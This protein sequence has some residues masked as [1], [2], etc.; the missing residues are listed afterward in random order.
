VPQTT[1]VARR[2]GRRALRAG[3]GRLGQR[4]WRGGTDD[5]GAADNRGGAAVWT[6]VTADLGKSTTD[7]GG[8][9]DGGDAAAQTNWYRGRRIGAA[10][11]SFFREVERRGA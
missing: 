2:C 11:V 8:A 3:R 10:L 7:D 1:G 5:G 6:T 4:G 9:D